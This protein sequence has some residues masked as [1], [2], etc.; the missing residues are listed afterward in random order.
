MVPSFDKATRIK[1]K[2]TT[3]REAQIKNKSKSPGLPHFQYKNLCTIFN[4]ENTSKRINR[5]RKQIKLL[6]RKTS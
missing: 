2:Q 4:L 1:Q 3:E 6:G 5:E